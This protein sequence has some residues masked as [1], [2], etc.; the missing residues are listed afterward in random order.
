MFSEWYAEPGIAI[1]TSFNFIHGKKIAT[2]I[3]WALDF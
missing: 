1:A 2:N 3:G